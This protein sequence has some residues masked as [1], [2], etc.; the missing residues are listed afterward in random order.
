MVPA[1]LD[2]GS[3][4]GVARWSN[5][6][7][8][9][10]RDSGD[11]LLV[12]VGWSAE[13]CVDPAAL[14]GRVRAAALGV[15]AR[16]GDAIVDQLRA[17][18]VERSRVKTIVATHLHLDHIGGACDFPDAQVVCT[19]R[20]LRAFRGLR[21]DI[22]YRADDLAKSGRARTVILV[23]PPVLGFRASHDL[24]GDGEIVL[25]EAQ[26]HTPGLA[27]VALR[28]PNRTYVHVG[29]AVYQT[30]EY[31]LSRPGPSPVARITGWRGEE[32]K[33]TYAAIR[34]CEAHA[35]KPIVVPSHDMSVFERLPRKPAEI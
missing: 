23:G 34:A 12:D 27:A 6:I 5:T 15:R 20:E 2:G 26:G 32:M 21:R 28:T 11:V 10:V 9:A 31:G 7:A 30:W 1:I 29:D 13:A 22:G 24:F 25:C 4:L 14:L 35:C 16:P 33:R 17:L 18:G 3:P 8:V 19:D